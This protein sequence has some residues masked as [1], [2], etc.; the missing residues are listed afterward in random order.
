MTALAVAATPAA[1]QR[2]RLSMDPGWRFSLDDPAGAEQ[3]RF[4]DSRWRRL[5]LP[6]DWSIEGTPREDAPGGG[7]VGFFLTGIGWYRKS[8]RLPA[9]ARGRTAWLEFDGVYMHSDVWIN[10]VHLGRRPY[11]YI[12]FAYDVTRH[13]VPGIN[14]VAVRVD[15]SR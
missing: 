10:G 13:L 6:H 2:Q 14:V 7:R 12:G 8:F 9:G 1:A 4:D 15:N 3:P 11:G 5:D